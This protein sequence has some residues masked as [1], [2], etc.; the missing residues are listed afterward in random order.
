[1]MIQSRRSTGPPYSLRMA[2]SAGWAT[3]L[4]RATLTANAFLEAEVER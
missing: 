4:L 3:F 2:S 1:M